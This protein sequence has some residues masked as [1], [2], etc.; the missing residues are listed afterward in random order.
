MDSHSF[1][2]KKETLPFHQFSD[3]REAE[4]YVKKFANGFSTS[5][6]CHEGSYGGKVGLYE[7]MLEYHGQPTSVDDIT[8]PGDTVCGWLTKEEVLEKLEKV[9]ILSP[10][11]KDEPVFEFLNGL[12]SDKNG[13]YG[14]M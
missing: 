10:K 4:Q 1:G 12:T 9:K 6:I 11:H 7:L 3:G 8:A 2:E 14:E 13:F 5:V